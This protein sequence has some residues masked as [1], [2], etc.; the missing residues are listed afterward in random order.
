MFSKGQ[1]QDRQESKA[2]VSKSQW[3]KQQRYK[4]HIQKIEHKYV[5]KKGH[6]KATHMLELS[7]I[8]ARQVIPS[9]FETIKISSK[10][11]LFSRLLSP[12][13]SS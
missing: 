7:R 3:K 1:I 5:P 6:L 13:Q 12:G 10:A 4:F 9:Y 8:K 2:R 11:E